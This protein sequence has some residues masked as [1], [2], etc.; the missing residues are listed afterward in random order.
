MQLAPLPSYHLERMNW[1]TCKT[2]KYLLNVVLLKHYV[3][4]PTVLLKDILLKLQWLG[5]HV[6]IIDLE[7]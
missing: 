3:G 5:R 4:L 2:V 7:C 1:P 6:T